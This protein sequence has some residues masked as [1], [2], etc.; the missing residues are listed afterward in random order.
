[1]KTCEKTVKKGHKNIF[2]VRQ[3]FKETLKSTTL[4]NWKKKFNMQ[5]QE[6]DSKHKANAHN[7]FQMPFAIIRWMTDSDL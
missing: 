5:K 6:F 1:M 3:M 7:I 2:N 4:D